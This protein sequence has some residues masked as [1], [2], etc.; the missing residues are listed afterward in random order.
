MNPD[1]DDTTAALRS[2]SQQVLTGEPK[3]HRAWEKGVRWILSMQNDDGGWAAFEKNVDNELLNLLPI[4]GSKYL[5]KDSSSADL[6]G[7]TLEFLGNYTNMQKNNVVSKRG[8]D[9]ILQ[10][11]EE[12][13]SWYGRWGICYIYGTWAAITGLIASGVHAKHPSIQKSINWLL[14][15]QNRDGGWGESCKS[16]FTGSMSHWGP[17]T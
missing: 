4:E 16:D 8:I 15:I 12:N 17:V 7:R 5:L 3:F 11:Q 2:I 10:N 6:T 14:E 1:T 13:G 9:W